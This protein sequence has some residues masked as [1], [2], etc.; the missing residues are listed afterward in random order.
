LLR[1]LLSAH[2][3]VEIPH[4][5]RLLDMAGAIGWSVTHHAR[6]PTPGRDHA[7]ATDLAWGRPLIDQLMRHL[8]QHTGATVVGDK[9]PPDAARVPQLAAVF[10]DCQVIHIVRDGRDVVSSSLRA[11]AGRTAWRR[12]ATPP[13]PAQM[14][15]SW[16]AL[17]Q[18]ARRDGQ[19]LGKDRY[20]ELTY[21]GLIQTPVAVGR[22]LEDFL[23]IPTHKLFSDAL[24]GV[25]PGRSWHTTL[26]SAEVAE[27][28]VVPGFEAAL[29]A[30]GYPPSP[31]DPVPADTPE[32]CMARAASG[33]ADQ[34]VAE[35]CRAV[36]PRDAPDEAVAALLTEA[37]HPESLFAAMNARERDSDIITEAYARWMRARGLPAE[38]A[39]RLTRCP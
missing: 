18:S 28:R 24:S 3:D 38:L 26:S 32:A 6:T 9:Y 2:P 14:A 27:L 22:R 20:L 4:E 10:A 5:L 23:K 16:A 30:H 1:R 25:H 17:V 33:P 12:T 15:S 39:D 35:L 21:E 19:S 31:T 8:R 29:S 37:E 7:S 34:K 36:R 11:F 13:A